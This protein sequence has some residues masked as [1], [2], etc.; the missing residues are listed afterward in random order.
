MFFKYV[1]IDL[2]GCV[3]NVVNVWVWVRFILETNFR[4]SVNA[5]TFIMFEFV[6]VVSN[7]DMVDFEFLL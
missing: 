5:M 7:F 3:F 4:S 6:G 2:F 1:V